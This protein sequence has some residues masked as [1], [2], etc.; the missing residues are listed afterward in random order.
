[1]LPNTL[2]AATRAAVTAAAAAAAAAGRGGVVSRGAGDLRAP[3]FYNTFL[4][5]AQPVLI[6]G[7]MVRRC[8]C[9]VCELVTC[10]KLELGDLAKGRSIFGQNHQTPTYYR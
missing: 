5:R 3:E 1:M 8:K 4:S 6:T 9:L 2:D 10:S 7:L